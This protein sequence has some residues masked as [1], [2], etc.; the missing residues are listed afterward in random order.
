MAS[1]KTATSASATRGTGKANLILIEDFAD[2][3]M[4]FRVETDVPRTA[5]NKVNFDAFV[6]LIK[7]GDGSGAARK[8]IVDF[9]TTE[10]DH[11]G[12]S[13]TEAK[14]AK[15]M[16]RAAFWFGPASAKRKRATP[17]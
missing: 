7:S 2:G 17:K 8:K 15:N 14:G 10:V 12:T 13:P 5:K 3:S 6:A 1:K 9:L 4:S 16:I 11:L